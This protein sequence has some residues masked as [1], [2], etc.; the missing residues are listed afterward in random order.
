[1][2]QGGSVN[3]TFKTL[4]ATLTHDASTR[5]IALRSGI[6]PST[7]KR[8]LDGEIKVQTVVAICRAYSGALLPAFMAAGFITYDEARSMAGIA[9]LMVASDRE[10]VEEMLQRVIDAESTGEPRPELTEPVKVNESDFERADREFEEEL[11]RENQD[12]RVLTRSEG[13]LHFDIGVGGLSEDQIKARYDLAANTDRS[14]E[15]L[16]PDL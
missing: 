7:L 1:M 2:H 5:S 6:E 9:S 16:D 13:G 3:E 15:K 8:Q 12:G 4:L 11:A 14:A 10:L